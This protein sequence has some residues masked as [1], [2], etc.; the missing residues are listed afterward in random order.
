MISRYPIIPVDDI[1]TVQEMINAEEEEEFPLDFQVLSRHQQ[2]N[3]NL[4]N[5][6]NNG[7]PHYSKRFVQGD[8]ALIFYKEKIAIPSTLLNSIVSWYHTSLN[9]PGVNR[10]CETIQSHF[11]CK[12]LRRVVTDFVKSCDVCLHQKAPAQK[13][14]KL[15]PNL[16]THDPW[17]CVHID[18]FGPWSFTDVNGVDRQIK[19]MSIIDSGLRWLELHEYSSK[20]S[21][22]ISFIFDRE[23]LCRYP[24]P[25][26]VVF[27]NGTEFT[28]EFH[29]L[30]DSYGIQAR[31]TTV[32]NPQSNGIVE[33]T[34]LTIADSLRAMELGNR[35]FDDTTIHGVLQ[36]IAWG[37]RST[38]HTALQS[39][40]GQLTFGRDMI[41]PATY[42]ANWRDIN[43]RRE[44]NVLYNN[45]RENR[46]RLDHDYKPGELVYVMSK[47]ITRKLN[48]S[49]DGPFRIVQIHTNGTVTIQRSKH[50][51]ER[52]NI[53][54]L[55]P[56]H[57]SKSN[58]K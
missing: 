37:L 23:W 25:R 41:I 31:A 51:K 4:T 19:A 39:S 15:P 43:A 22:D 33:R 45:A 44:R 48:P 14:A 12:G 35:P 40:P 28:S 36:A 55:Y 57:E 1:N 9:H 21:E 11:A 3:S 50:V 56:V 46:S 29:E 30:L 52:L 32:K 26:Y 27:D 17:D 47:D 6:V 16:T 7:A 58:A 18:L 5:L 38:F 2:R 34:H 8:T 13:Y 53:Q 42:L 49:K 20:R 24:R 54:R 10:T